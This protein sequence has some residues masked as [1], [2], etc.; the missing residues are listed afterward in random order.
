MK[1]KVTKFYLVLVVLAGLY[2]VFNMFSNKRVLGRQ[3]PLQNE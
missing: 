3:D 2:I 1:R